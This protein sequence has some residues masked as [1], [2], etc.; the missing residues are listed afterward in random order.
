M[1]SKKQ[2]AVRQAFRQAVA[3]FNFQPETGDYSPGDP[4]PRPR[5]W[6]YNQSGAMWY[7]NYFMQQTIPTYLAGGVP[8]WCIS[9]LPLLQGGSSYLVGLDGPTWI[10]D[11]IE[12]P[13]GVIANDFDPQSGKA[14]AVFNINLTGVAST[15]FDQPGQC[16]LLFFLDSSRMTGNTLYVRGSFATYSG[17]PATFNEVPVSGP[18]LRTLENSSSGWYY[19]DVKDYL[20]QMVDTYES[21][22]AIIVFQCLYE[23][24]SDYYNYFIVRGSESPVYPAQLILTP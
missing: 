9:E 4:G 24:Y 14:R 6:W 2:K 12:L 18:I 13:T 19:V 3:C 1:A 7:Y 5:T 11:G 8:T 20:F 15:Q 21:N 22:Y 23:G 10:N 16:L 17:P